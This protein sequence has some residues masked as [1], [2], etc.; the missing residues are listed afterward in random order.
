M[1]PE[2]DLEKY[3]EE[4][5]RGVGLWEPGEQRKDYLGTRGAV[6]CTRSG[7]GLE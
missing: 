2:E 7:D 3:G 1:R 5:S 4:G 6:A